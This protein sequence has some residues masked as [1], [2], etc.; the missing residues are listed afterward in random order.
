MPFHPHNANRRQYIERV[1][2]MDVSLITFDSFISLLY[3][4]NV[5]KSMIFLQSKRKSIVSY[6]VV[7]KSQSL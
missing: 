7:G 3:Y 2:K 5:A 4:N 6:N 1:K